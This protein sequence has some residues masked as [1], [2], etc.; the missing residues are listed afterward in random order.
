M[1]ATPD[2]AGFRNP[3]DLTAEPGCPVWAAGV[4]AAL[5]LLGTAGVAQADVTD[6][7]DD[8]GN[9]TFGSFT[10]YSGL[11]DSRTLSTDFRNADDYLSANEYGILHAG[12]ASEVDRLTSVSTSTTSSIPLID[13][14]FA[15]PLGQE[16]GDDS[17]IALTTVPV[18]ALWEPVD[19]GA[20]PSDGVAPFTDEQAGLLDDVIR[21]TQPEQGEGTTAANSLTTNEAL[22][23]G[24]G[25]D[26]ADTAVFDDATTAVLGAA[27]GNEFPLDG[28]L[29]SDD[30]ALLTRG[31]TD[32]DFFDAGFVVGDPTP[33]LPDVTSTLATD[34]LAT[35][36]LST[37]DLTL[38]VPTD[39]SKDVQPLPSSTGDLLQDGETILAGFNGAD[40]GNRT[41]FVAVPALNTTT[42]ATY[43]G[44]TKQITSGSV[45]DGTQ[46]GSEGDPTEVTAGVTRS[47]VEF[48]Q[49][50]P[51]GLGTTIGD[52]LVLAQA[53]PVELSDDTAVIGVEQPVPFVGGFTAAPLRNVPRILRNVD[54]TAQ[55]FLDADT[56]D[57]GP[58]PILAP[59]A[60]P[61]VFALSPLSILINTYENATVIGVKQAAS[62]RAAGAP[63]A[64]ANAATNPLRNLPDAVTT[65]PR[66]AAVDALL[67][68]PQM[69]LPKT[70]NADTDMLIQAGFSGIVGAGVNSGAQWLQTVL[71]EMQRR[72][73]EHYLSA[74]TG[75][76][77][78]VPTPKPITLALPARPLPYLAAP[79]AITG[80]AMVDRNV[81]RTLGVCQPSASDTSNAN[82]Y[83]DIAMRS[84]AKG[85]GFQ[86]AIAADVL[87]DQ[88]ELA[89]KLNPGKA[90]RETAPVVATLAA[91]NAIAE[92]LVVDP[93]VDDDVFR[94]LRSTAQTL[95][96]LGTGGANVLA[97]E[98]DPEDGA[99]V[100][101]GR[102]VGNA[103]L[104]L[105][106]PAIAGVTS[107]NDPFR[108]AE[109]V[110]REI[111]GDDPLPLVTGTEIARAD[112][113]WDEASEALHTGLR[114]PPTSLQG[115]L[116]SV[117][118]NTADGLG[119][120]VFGFAGGVASPFGGGETFDAATERY[121]ESAASFGR[122]RDALGVAASETGR[123][124]GDV[125]SFAG[126]LGTG[127]LNLLQ[128]GDVDGPRAGVGTTTAPQDP[129][130]TERELWRDRGVPTGPGSSWE[131]P[132][133]G[134]YL[135]GALVAPD[136]TRYRLPA[137][138]SPLYVKVQLPN[139]KPIIVIISPKL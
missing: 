81:R 37:G 84:I 17:P 46:R 33:A 27:L 47:F 68:N 96:D 107:A 28:D 51:V 41:A 113:R 36:V 24:G 89:R 127:G 38:S 7:L 130:E 134:R 120:L 121:R 12:D 1:S 32:E 138:G 78:T 34:V 106:E 55:E 63:E 9:A 118:G 39:G 101:I 13:R 29:T 8:I 131:N 119:D 74:R 57:S 117:A 109:N 22:A 125:W 50:V 64:V 132:V 4:V 42:T 129:T 62:L 110:V 60:L 122:A 2:P 97:G 73:V 90:L 85:L 3:Y 128:F 40:S 94:S 31:D 26:D 111:R 43:A 48:Q 83:C 116:G 59:E 133:P 102:G 16:G 87:T 54:P 93:A 14:D 99:G 25:D 53:E 105:G 6:P 114:T 11:D 69:P 21:D 82:T 76:R 126:D 18:G 56:A 88:W 86:S 124:A 61:Y 98:T 91:Q 108:V 95:S 137:D 10:Q 49:D 5:S 100:N 80:A 66:A 67:Q 92:L 136:G 104:A 19:A 115:A 23:L 70:G 65:L 20:G 135:D 58:G 45:E 15:D 75:T 103:L 52:G 30:A 77:V 79:T 139:G 123:I 35:D 71:P 72:N 112:R 44:T